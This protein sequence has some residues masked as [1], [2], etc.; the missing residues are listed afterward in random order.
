[1][2]RHYEMHQAKGHLRNTPSTA[3]RRSEGLRN[4]P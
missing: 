4:Q 2:L 1:M 3:K